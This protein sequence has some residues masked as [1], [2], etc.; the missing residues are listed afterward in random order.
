MHNQSLQSRRLGMA[1]LLLLAWFLAAPFAVAAPAAY[2]KAIHA[3]GWVVVPTGKDRCEMGACWVLDRDKRL[4]ITNRHVVTDRTEVLVYFPTYNG[5]ELI[6]NSS[7]YLKHVAPIPGKVRVTDSHRD[8]ALIEVASLPD[9]VRAISLAQHSPDVGAAV[10]SIGNSGLAEQPPGRGN[11]W[12]LREGKVTEKAGFRVLG[13]SST[14]QRIQARIFLT[15]SGTRP[16]DSGG[17]MVDDLGRLVGV[18]RGNSVEDPRIAHVVDI[19]EVREFVARWKHPIKHGP[20]LEGTWTISFGE[21]G[22]ESFLGM[23]FQ[24]DGTCMVETSTKTMPG[25]YTYFANTLTLD[26]PEM[27]LK[28]TLKVSWAGK[29]EFSFQSGPKKFTVDRR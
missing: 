23:S 8:L 20:K 3:T 21:A 19:S 27:N 25:K 10:H 5:L 6:T 29:D 15:S 7:Y 13:S 1:L 9:D 12:R 17:P 4:V 28:D 24:A 14:D 16:G 22:K 2:Y 26:V 18:V 11:L